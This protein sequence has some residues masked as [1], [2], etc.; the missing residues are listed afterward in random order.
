MDH[1]ESKFTPDKRA[2]GRLPRRHVVIDE[3]SIRYIGKETN[4]LEESETVGVSED[5]Y[6]EY[7]NE[8]RIDWKEVLNCLTPDLAAMA[9]VSPR[10]L[11]YLKQ[12]MKHGEPLKMK[13]ST[14]RKIL[15]T[16]RGRRKLSP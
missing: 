15:K 12:R 3:D 2:T 7:V 13:P 9:G 10:N 5:N 8:G 16:W 1:A 4:D 11:R 14:K 6:I